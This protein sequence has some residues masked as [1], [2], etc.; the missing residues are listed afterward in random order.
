MT[1]EQSRLRS[2]IVGTRVIARPSGRRL[3]VVNQLWI[4]LNRLEVVAWEIQENLPFKRIAKKQKVLRFGVHWTIN[5]VLEIDDAALDDP[6][7]GGV[8]TT[9]FS[10]LINRKVITEWGDVLGRV[11]DFKVDVITSK[12]ETL[13]MDSLGL[14]Q[15]SDRVVSTYELPVGEIASTRSDRIIVFEGSEEKLMQLSVG[16]LERLGLGSAPWERGL[17]NGYV[18]P[19]SHRHRPDEIDPPDDY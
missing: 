9:L 4:D 2:E 10:S 6:L 13:V 8:D 1:F 19:V 3:G 14:P 12:L 7:D 16:L 15:I 17:S 5:N 18:M 11:R